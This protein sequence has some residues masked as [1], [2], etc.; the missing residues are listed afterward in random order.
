M[1]TEL[2][3][4]DPTPP[5][6]YFLS[7][8]ERKWSDGRFVSVGLDSDTTQLPTGFDQLSFN[9]KIIDETIDLAGAYKP[10]AAF[11]ERLGPVGIQTLIATVKHIKGLDPDMP[12]ILDAKRADIGSTNNGYVEFAFDI[13]GADAITVHP[14]LGKEALK[15]FF[16]RADKG[17]IVLAR[18]SNPG[19]GEFQDL[20]V[21]P[22]EPL[23]L[24]V[25]RTV[26]QDW[27][28][29][30]NAGLVVGATYP[31]ELARVREIAP[32]LPILIPGVGKQGGDLEQAVRNGRDTN[33][34]GMIINSSRDIIFASSGPDFAQ[35]ARSK[36]QELTDGV[37]QYRMAA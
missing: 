31:E 10:N 27:N 20:F 35:A 15:P 33:A 1:I 26:A 19:A 22:N 8:L 2:K 7:L 32:R 25:A 24:R 11:Y 29:N 30:G 14:Y 17:V 23:Y 3:G 6:S 36:L 4:G 16:D 37:N 5:D 28:V 18:T 34:Q 12:V 9:K 13:V 21:A